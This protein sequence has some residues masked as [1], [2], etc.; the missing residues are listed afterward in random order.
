MYEL[1]VV[2]SCL[3][4]LIHKLTCFMFFIVA[5]EYL[6]ANFLIKLFVALKAKIDS[7]YKLPLLLVLARCCKR[8]S[9]CKPQQ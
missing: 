5:L 3:S 1:T 7:N 4:A 8:Q 2:F 6:G 9:C